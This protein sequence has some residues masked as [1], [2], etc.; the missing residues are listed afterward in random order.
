M[1]VSVKEGFQTSN[2]E[3]EQ[4]S[5]NMAAIKSRDT[6]PEILTRRLLHALGYRFRLHL[7]DLP[8]C[9]DVVLPKYKTVI[10]I[11]GCFWHQH[12]GCKFSSM[13]KS[14]QDYWQKKLNNNTIRD[15]INI[16]KLITLGWN[17]IVVWECETKDITSLRSRL[18]NMIHNS[19]SDSRE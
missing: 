10:F 16:A 18:T 4:R 5:K 15:E 11:N 8:G 9:P 13:P 17:V 2:D 12:N 14:N 19:Q 6:K 3:T 7:K 1:K